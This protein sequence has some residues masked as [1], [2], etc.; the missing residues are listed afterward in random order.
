MKNIISS[1][2]I[3]AFLGTFMAPL[4]LAQS[5]EYM[6]GRQAGKEAAKHDVNQ[7]VE[8]FWGVLLGVFL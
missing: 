6:R 7:I 5:S 2:L 1:L 8:G 4:T 3:V